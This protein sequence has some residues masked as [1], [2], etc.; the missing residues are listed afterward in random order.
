[1]AQLSL[2]PTGKVSPGKVFA[3]VAV[4]VFLAALDLFI[5]NIGFPAI[6][7]DFSGSTVSDV[8]W[9]L[10][11]YAI[12]FAALL[13]PAG[14]LGDILGRRRVF[15]AGLLAFG[16]G[17][18][19]C[20]AAPSLEFLI[21]A[22]VLQGVGAA[23]ITPTS[24]GLLL[25]AFPPQRRAVAI[26][27][28]AAI[29]AV[30]A[31]SGPPLGGLLTEISWHWIFIVNVPLALVTAVVARRV[32]GE[33][34][35]PD[36]S[37]LPDGLGTALL[38]G[39]VGLLTLGLVKGSDWGW[40]SR[41][42]ASLAGAALLGAAFVARS[43][44][45]PAPVLELS[46]LRVPAFALASLSA[47]LFFASFAVM[48]LSSVIFLTDV[49]GYSELQAGL[50]LSPG[51]LAAAAFAPVSGRLANRFGPGPIGT[52]GALAFAAG[53]GWWIWRI[54]L[55]AAYAADFLP[56][57][58]IG[59]VGV[60]LV[61]PSFTVAATAT[62]PPERLATG[63]GAQTTFRQIGATLGVAAFVAI[64]GTPAPDQILAAF[65]NT[66]LFMIATALAAALAL[67]PI[68]RPATAAS[69]PAAPAGEAAARPAEAPV[70]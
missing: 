35:D 51:P 41:V 31:A 37:A 33:I 32:L 11:V 26:G 5:V 43:S 9:V 1:M 46:I 20:A 29:G 64:L 57:M 60:G 47:A 48:L 66:R 40:D 65:D 15:V 38:I 50:A 70:R 14:K 2:A 4:G 36:R 19:L 22:R 52:A 49:W 68:R 16:L 21:G 12:V 25:P 18:A 55:D 62:L 24:L 6:Q 28:W 59:G 56:G 44:R 39:S 13:V 61:L 53:T 7:G 30:G 54:G 67:V 27:G 58:V 63:I 23:A 10:N 34:R 3:I 69:E 17:S 42:I 45:H 8:S